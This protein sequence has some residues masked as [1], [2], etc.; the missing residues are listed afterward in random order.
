MTAP[1]PTVGSPEDDSARV[2]SVAMVRL[3]FEGQDHE[4][5]VSE[6][7][8]IAGSVVHWFGCQD[9]DAAFGWLVVEQLYRVA[10]Y[11]H[12]QPCTCPPDV[13]ENGEVCG[14]CRALCLVADQAD[15]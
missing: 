14:R 11:V 6:A 12:S 4:V 9:G 5:L 1:L 10:E 3:D 13:V 2:R 7:S 15:S 8:D